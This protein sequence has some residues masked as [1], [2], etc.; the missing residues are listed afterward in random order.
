MDG[1]G[2]RMSRVGFCPSWLTNEYRRGFTGH[3]AMRVRAFTPRAPMPP[4]HTMPAFARIGNE[5]GVGVR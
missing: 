1:S 3:A 5:S 4:R 2:M